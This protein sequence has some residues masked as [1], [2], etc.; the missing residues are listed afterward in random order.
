MKRHIR[1]ISLLIVI[2][3]QSIS[4]TS[5]KTALKTIGLLAGN[6]L[7]MTY[8]ALNTTADTYSRK[9]YSAKKSITVLSEYANMSRITGEQLVILSKDTSLSK[10]D[11]KFILQVA[12]I[13]NDLARQADAYTK[14]IRSSKPEDAEKFAI[15][16]DQNWAKI[17]KLLGIEE[18]Q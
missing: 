15:F 18:Q 10:A 17:R 12:S 8:I 13:Q 6:N 2:G 1:I 7:Y 16:R 11:K 14:F 4:A 3:F 5:S 9:V